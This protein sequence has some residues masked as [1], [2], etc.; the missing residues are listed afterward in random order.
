[1]K[2]LEKISP[3]TKIDIDSNICFFLAGISVSTDFDFYSM[4]ITRNP[5][6]Q[7]IIDSQTEKEIDRIKNAVKLGKESNSYQ[8]YR[9]NL[10][11]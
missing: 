7:A 1:M 6:L 2:L 8:V 11:S 9:A 3:K 10:E 5:D 4:P